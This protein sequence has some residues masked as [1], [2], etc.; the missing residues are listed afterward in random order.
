MAEWIDRLVTAR[1][2]DHRSDPGSALSAPPGLRPPADASQISEFEGWLRQPIEPGYRQFL[3]FSDGMENF[4]SG[5]PLLGWRDL[6][7]GDTLARALRFRDVITGIDVHL[8]EGLTEDAVL[9]PVSVNGD[10]TVGI[11]MVWDDESPEKRY[12]WVG[13]GDAAFFSTLSEVFDVASGARSWS[14]F[15]TE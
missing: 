8:D 4:R 11:F 13:N 3:E 5:M 12:F 2:D 10:G 14:E 6:P 1:I 9:A 15:S 7:S